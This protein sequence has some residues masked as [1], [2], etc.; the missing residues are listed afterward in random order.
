MD[1]APVSRGRPLVNFTL[2]VRALLPLALVFSPLTA[3]AEVR[4][5]AARLIWRAPAGS[6]C[7][8]ATDLEG[9]VEERLRRRVFAARADVVVEGRVERTEGTWTA[10][11][12]MRTERGEPIGTREIRSEAESC[13]GLDESLA[14]VVALMIDVSEERIRLRIP[15]RRERTRGW[16]LQ[17]EVGGATALGWLPG[18]ALGL[19]IGLSVDPPWGWPVLVDGVAWADERVSDAQGGADLEG[20]QAAVA[21]CPPIVRGRR[22]GVAACV[23]GGAAAIRATGYDFLDNDDGAAVLAFVSA[24]LRGSFRLAGPLMMEAGVAGTAPLVRHRFFYEDPAGVQR[25]LYRMHAVAGIA[26]LGLGVAI[27]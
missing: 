8:A 3:D 25:V 23:G 26:T 18:F 19:R 24:G 7:I 9:A 6:G 22:L 13:S 4:P 17:T 16:H 27:P 21:V 5:V 20:R 10:R 1:V 12:E 14:L 2:R 15:V 11:L